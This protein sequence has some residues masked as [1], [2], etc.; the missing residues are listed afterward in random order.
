MN[1]K[2][3]STVVKA[4]L[5]GLKFIKDDYLG[6]YSGSKETAEFILKNIKKASNINPYKA[7]NYKTHKKEY[8]TFYNNHS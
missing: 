6:A 7:K 3:E 4:S 2:I 8:I 5:N 1:P